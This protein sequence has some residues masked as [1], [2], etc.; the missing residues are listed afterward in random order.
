[1]L[2]IKVPRFL[3]SPVMIWVKCDDARELSHMETACLVTEVG[4][5]Q[6]LVIVAPTYYDSAQMVVRG[7]QVGTSCSDSSAWLV[8]FP[9]GQRLM[10]PQE[11]VKNV[12]PI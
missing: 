3:E 8:D 7:V 11:T 10:I 5:E 12:R 4:G 9:S 2:D 6:Q 1:M